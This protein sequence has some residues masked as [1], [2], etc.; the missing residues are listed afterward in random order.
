MAILTTLFWFQLRKTF[1]LFSLVKDL[2]GGLLFCA[3]DKRVKHGKEEV[4]REVQFVHLFFLRFLFFWCFWHLGFF[5]GKE[6]VGTLI[7][8]T[9]WFWNLKCKPSTSKNEVQ[10][11]ACKVKTT[12]KKD[13]IVTTKILG[14]YQVINAKT[15]QRFYFIPGDGTEASRKDP[16]FPNY[17]FL[18]KMFRFSF[19]DV[20]DVQRP[21]SFLFFCS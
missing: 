14:D 7:P 16:S 2:A 10:K 18:L 1:R 9:V 20:Q 15:I 6:R 19:V 12:R 5:T 11:V 21:V 4:F 3:H 13:S 17:W 8:L